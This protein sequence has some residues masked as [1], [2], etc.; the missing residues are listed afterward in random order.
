VRRWLDLLYDLSGAL[1]AVCLAGIGVVMLAQAVG[2]EMGMLLRGADDIA[3][4]LC[5]ASAFL[6]LAHTFRRG[7]L[8]RVALWVGMLKGRT[9]WIAEVFALTVTVVF[10][11][12]A[13]LAVSRF[14]FQSWEMNEI[15]QGLLQIPI[16]IPQ[17]SLVVGMCIFLVAV[18]DE[19]IVVLRGKKPA[20]QLAEEDR[21][22]RGDF[23]EAL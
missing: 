13:A 14:V 18:I 12:Y 4:W 7:E 17:A 23:S 9:R 15:N 2:R 6:G 20:Y 16:W 1:A 5:G 10:V 22:A 3:A 11:A 19:L 8:V 21:I